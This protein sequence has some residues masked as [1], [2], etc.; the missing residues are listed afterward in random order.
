MC[1][2]GLRVL[3]RTLTG[4]QVVQFEIHSAVLSNCERLGKSN[5]PAFSLR[6]TLQFD[7]LEDFSY[8]EHGK[9]TALSGNFWPLHVF[10]L[11]Y[12]ATCSCNA[13]DVK[14]CGFLTGQGNLSH[15]LLLDSL[16]QGRLGPPAQ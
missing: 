16:F 4:K 9:V 13:R 1:L 3:K 11:R 2:P 14:R 8:V 10:S 15:V 5:R 6:A 12:G 7:R